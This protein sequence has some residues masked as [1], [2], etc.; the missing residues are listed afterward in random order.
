M[1]IESVKGNDTAR[2]NL[3]KQLKTDN[4][5][6]GF[7]MDCIFLEENGEAKTRYRRTLL[8]IVLS[9]AEVATEHN[10]DTTAARSTGG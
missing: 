1:P 9:I 6:N 10:E 8:L 3:D 7:L 5:L 2:V 4:L